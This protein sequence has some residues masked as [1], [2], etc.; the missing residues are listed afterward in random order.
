MSI[1]KS[2]SVGKGDMFYINHGSDNFTVI[3]CNLNS[4]NKKK[5][6][7]EITYLSKNNVTRFISTHPDED[8]FHGIEYFD[9]REEIINFYVVK[10]NVYKE[11]KTDSFKKY[12]KLHD[13][14]RAFYIYKDCSRKWM[15]QGDEKHGSAGIN[16]LWPNTKDEDFELA[17]KEVKKGKSPNN[18]SPIIEY[19]LEKGVVSLWLGDLDTDFLM[20]IQDKVTWPKVDLLFAPHHGRKSGSIPD[21]VLKQLE[22]KVIIIGEADNEELNY[23]TDYNTIKQNSAENLLFSCEEGKVHCYSSKK[24]YTEKFLEDESL[25]DT[26]DEFYIGSFRTHRKNSNF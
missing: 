14:S 12:K 9:S 25:V 16:I 23:Y 7:D 13:S 4:D 5:I 2:F 24:D 8:H 10:N 3:D 19:S 20:K 11:I 21:Y 15:N 26:P 1:I 22:P 17:L 18:I 6:M